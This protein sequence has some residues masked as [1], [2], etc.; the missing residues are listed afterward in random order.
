MIVNPQTKEDKLL[1]VLDDCEA[2]VLLTEGSLTRTALAAAASA[3][4]VKAVVA[5]AA[6]EGVEGALAFEDVLASAEPE[7]T[8]RGRSRSTSPRSS[9]RRGAPAFPRA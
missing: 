2:A 6:P 1:Y 7:P 8:P 4:S 3:A 9:T 5:D